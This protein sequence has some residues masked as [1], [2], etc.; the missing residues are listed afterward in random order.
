M[1]TFHERSINSGPIYELDKADHTDMS[2][3]RKPERETS[4][5]LATLESIGIDEKQGIT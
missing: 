1:L 5:T 2:M 4:V 3:D